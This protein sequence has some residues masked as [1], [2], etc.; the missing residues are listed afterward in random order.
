MREKLEFITLARATKIA[1]VLLNIKETNASLPLI[2]TPQAAHT[3][4]SK[5][6]LKSI[7]SPEGS[8]QDTN[9]VVP[10]SYAE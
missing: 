6:Y 3:I 4:I 7:C 5:K 2:A 1:N 9:K 8:S 10:V